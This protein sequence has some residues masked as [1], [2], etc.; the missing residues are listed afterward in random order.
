[1]YRTDYKHTAQYAVA[2]LSS[3]CDDRFTFT[4]ANIKKYVTLICTITADVTLCNNG[5]LETPEQV[6]LY[7]S[8]H[9]IFEM[10]EHIQSS[11]TLRFYARAHSYHAQ[12][13]K[14]SMQ[15]FS[16]LFLFLMTCF[17]LKQPSSGVLSM[18]K[19][20]HCINVH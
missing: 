5:S 7:I 17:G 1:M 16:I 13:I 20:W 19:L 4:A 18:P 9:F 15:L 6:H 14:S 10:V 11:V 8:R 2:F 12:Y 3:T